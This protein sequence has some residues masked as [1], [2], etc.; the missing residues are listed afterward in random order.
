MEETELY[1]KLKRK[2]A[3]N[4][5]NLSWFVETYCQEITNAKGVKIRY[6]AIAQQL[7][8]YTTICSDLQNA[9]NNYLEEK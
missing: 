8:G 9:V 7:L 3:K 1:K 2:F 6:S 5:S 4:G